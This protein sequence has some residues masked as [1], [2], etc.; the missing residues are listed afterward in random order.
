MTSETAD[1]GTPH[2]CSVRVLTPDGTIEDR[3][4]ELLEEIGSGAAATV[5]R[6]RDR[7][8]GR[9]VAV[10]VLHEEQVGH[11]KAVARFLQ[12]RSILLALRHDNI[13]RVRDLIA[14][15]DGMLALVM[16]LV[17]GGSLRGY[18]AERGTLPLA[19]AASLLAQVADGLHAAH[20]RSVVHRDLKPDN[21]L[22]DRGLDG[23]PRARL[24]DFGIARVLDQPGLTT[25]GAVIGTPNYMAP[26]L[27]EGGLPGPG[28][29]VYALG[30][31]FYELLV[32]RPPYADQ[33][34]ATILVRH[35]RGAPR[36]RAGIPKPAWRLIESCLARDPA[37]RPSAAA[38]GVA[39]RA[40][41]LQAGGVAAL[42]RL[43]LDTGRMP[44]RRRPALAGS[45]V[46]V[47]CVAAALVGF[48]GR[49]LIDWYPR[50]ESGNAA[51][52]TGPSPVTSARPSGPA[53]AAPTATPSPTPSPAAPTRGRVA[54]PGAASAAVKVPLPQVFGS[55]RCQTGLA[56][57]ANQG[58]L[59]RPCYT[60][61][62]AVRVRGSMLGGQ[63][64]VKVD[65]T[66]VLRDAD[67]DAQVATNT[68]PG[69]TP[70]PTAVEMSCGPFDAQPP[71]GHRYVVVVSWRYQ[72]GSGVPGGS[73]RGD[74]FSW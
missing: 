62:P 45:L 38:L 67:T 29:D 14:T 28:V 24:T 52:R 1:A 70:T 2:A 4:Y 12:E 30:V 53:S 44:A 37:R 64:N 66:V 31:M 10:K 42:P 63:S 7:A 39:L 73:T 50:V 48:G 68:C 18:L 61:G 9:E 22:V 15:P 40:L 6:G 49:Y 34:Q 56:Y 51:P 35:L 57:A 41:A 32:G 17:H 71:R 5:W 36:K 47:A 55:W 8:S 25:A 11:P 58:A 16:D 20:L 46:A 72:S 3:S 33:M 43:A 60:T 54:L 13:V 19:E 69:L 65:L 23:A 59:V 27:I 21:V 74:A 26:E